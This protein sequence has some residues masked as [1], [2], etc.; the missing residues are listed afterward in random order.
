VSSAD[1]GHGGSLICASQ[2]S[3]ITMNRYRI[4]AAVLAG[5]A[6]LI[7]SPAFAVNT[8]NI[9]VSLTVEEECTMATT[10]LTFGTTGIIDTALTGSADITIECTAESP[11]AIALDDG[12]NGAGNTSARK[13]KNTVEADVVNYQLYSTSDYGTVWGDEIGD[14]TVDSAS[15]TGADEVYT[16]YGQ[17]LTHQNVSAGSYVDT[18]TATIWYGEDLTP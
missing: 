4:A 5:T 18:I 16:V 7:A 13:L 15:A 10:P 8:G 12:D 3:E 14:D 11:Y 9:G 1:H 6:A 17:I 2:G